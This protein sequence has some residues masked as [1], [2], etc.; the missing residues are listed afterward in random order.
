[1]SRMSI[2]LPEDIHRQVK[3]RAAMDGTTVA[4]VFRHL[5]EEYARGR[6]VQV[7]ETIVTDTPPVED[8]VATPA[9]DRVPKEPAEGIVHRETQPDKG[10]DDLSGVT[11]KTGAMA[12]TKIPRVSPL[13]TDLSKTA[14]AKGKSRK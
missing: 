13:R 5:A 7:A 10:P 1:M 11:I 6:R 12:G 4:R 2:D 9:L 8:W 14:Q 3:A